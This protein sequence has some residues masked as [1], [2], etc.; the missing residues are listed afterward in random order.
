MVLPMMR[1]Q[2]L[3][4]IRIVNATSRFAPAYVLSLFK[5]SPLIVFSISN[6]RHR[7]HQNHPKH[8]LKV[9]CVDPESHDHRRLC[10]HHLD[11]PEHHPHPHPKHL[12]QLQQRKRKRKLLQQH[13]LGTVSGVTP[14]PSA[15]TRVPA[16]KD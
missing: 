14:C 1:M 5:K 16:G 2:T 10:A 9:V 4:T 13:M 7:H 15:T 11:P 6:N 12:H 8:R 3:M